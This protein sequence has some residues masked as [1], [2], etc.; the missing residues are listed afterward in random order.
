CN[1]F[2][3]SFIDKKPSAFSILGN[4]NTLFAVLDINN[5]KKLNFMKKLC[6]NRSIYKGGAKN[7]QKTIKNNGIRGKNKLC[8]FDCIRRNFGFILATTSCR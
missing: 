1:S 7:G 3:R 2:F 6:Y 5:L 8:A 4:Y